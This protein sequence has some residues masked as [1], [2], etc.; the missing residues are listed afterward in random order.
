[1]KSIFNCKFHR[2]G[3]EFRAD[4]V[5]KRCSLPRK[6]EKLMYNK[7]IIIYFSDLFHL[8][9]SKCTRKYHM[10]ILDCTRLYPIVPDCTRLYSIVPD[11]TTH[12]LGLGTFGYFW[13]FSDVE[14]TQMYPNVPQMYPNVPQ[15]Y[16]NVPECTP[17]VPWYFCGT[18]VVLLWYFCSTAVV[19][20]AMGLMTI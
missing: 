2:I 17:N 15:M 5:T 14:N 4:V 20:F 10:N 11:C 19:L 3:D 9:R 13:V 8:F 18:Y 6:G 12:V 1:M 16:P 7:Y